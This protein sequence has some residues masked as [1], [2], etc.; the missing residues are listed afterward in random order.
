MKI[1]PVLDHVLVRMDPADKTTR[2]GIHIPDAFQKQLR[3]GEV[4]AV[5]SGMEC[6]VWEK[7]ANGGQHERRYVMSPI[8]VK[9][10]ERVICTMYGGL[11]VPEIDDQILFTQNEILAVI[12]P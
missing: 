9:P 6:R 2:G 10:G 4:L 8:E 11:P 12:E 3:F 1:R 7:G 5:G